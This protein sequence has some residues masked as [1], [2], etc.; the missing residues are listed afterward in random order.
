MRAVTRA[1]L[2]TA[3]VG[4]AALAQTVVSAKSGMIHYV[5]GS[6]FLGDEAVQNKFGAFPEMKENTTL[7]TEE[8]RVEVLLTPGVF[9]R[10]AEHSSIRMVTNRLIDTRVEFLS[11]SG[12]VE[13]GEILKDNSV[14]LVHRDAAIH[15]EKRGLYRVA[16]QPAELRVFEGEATVR[17]GDRAVE[18]KD[19]KMVAL[20]GD[21]A[22]ARFDKEDTDALDR[23]SRR[24]GESVAMANLSAAN[25]LRRS[26]RSWS[27][28]GWYWNPYFG[29]LTFVPG[30]GIY[31]SPYGYRFYSPVAVYRVYAPR[32]AWDSAAFSGR[33]G[34]APYGYGGMG[35]TSG[36]YSGVVAAAPVSSAPAAHAPASTAAAAPAAPVASSGGGGG[37]GSRK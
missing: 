28:S 25:S 30:S 18:V 27:S 2:C 9:L 37:A 5:E 21:L 23:W 22:V 33:G 31:S 15:L 14:T 29:M 17:L 26:G 6:V 35:R 12:V 16:T 8:G 1:V 7:R 4:A 11:G 34:G 10:L 36:G 13:A 19:G 32:P 20:E 24:R 3:L